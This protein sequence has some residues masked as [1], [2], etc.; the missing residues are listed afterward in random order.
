M[1]PLKALPVEC[2]LSI[3][4]NGMNNDSRALAAGSDALK[5]QQDSVQLTCAATPAIPDYLQDNY[6]WAYLHLIMLNSL[7]LEE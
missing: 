4:K 5:A 6:W 2:Q 1:M 3:D 7:L